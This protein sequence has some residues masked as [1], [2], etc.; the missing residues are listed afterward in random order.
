MGFCFAKLP[1]KSHEQAA[2]KPK[3]IYSRRV[4]SFVL[5]KKNTAKL[6]ESVLFTHASSPPSSVVSSPDPEF[7]NQVS[8]R[9]FSSL[10]KESV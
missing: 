7:Y 3:L 1:E 10:L 5:K 2:W 9:C 8:L 6:Y 4:V